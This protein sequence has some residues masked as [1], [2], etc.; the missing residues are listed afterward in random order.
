MD[1]ICIAFSTAL[2]VLAG[3]CLLASLTEAPSNRKTT[4]AKRAMM[5]RSTPGL[6]NLR[7]EKAVG[8]R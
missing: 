2:F 3:P 6:V 5:A 1:I 4:Q 7:V 8:M